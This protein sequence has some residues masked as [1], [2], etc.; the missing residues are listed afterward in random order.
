MSR[1]KSLFRRLIIRTLKIDIVTL[2]TTLTIIS[3]A[4]VIVYSYFVNYKAIL[5]YSKGTMER[6]SI[7]IIDRINNI[8]ERAIE[9][10]ENTSGLFI[11]T[12][13]I[14]VKNHELFPFMLNVLKFNQNLTAFFIGFSNGDML[15]AGNIRLSNQKNYLSEP[16]KP[17][18]NETAYRMWYV[19]IS[20]PVYHELW[21]YKDVNFNTIDKETIP[22]IIFPVKQRPWYIGAE[23][24]KQIFWTQVF[25]YFGMND[26]GVAVA[27][28]IYDQQGNLL[29]VIG[30]DISFHTMSNFIKKQKIGRSGR[31]YIISNTGTLIAP[32]A[33]E[34]AH[35][36]IPLPV[37]NAAFQDFQKNHHQNFSFKYQQKRYL[38]YFSS[39][40]SLFGQKWMILTIVP[41]NDFYAN[42]IHTQFEIVL[43]TLAILLISILIIIHF[44]K[45]ISKPI[46]KIGKEIDKIT[47]LDF[48]SKER[49]R[50][51]II[52]IRMINYSVLALKNAIRSFSR[53]VPKEIVKQLLAQGKAITLNVEKKT[54]TIFFSDIQNFTTISENYNIDKLMTLL[55]EYFDGLSKIILEHQGT[56][57]KYIGDS[58]MAFW[59]APIAMPD[60]AILACTAALKC[61]AYLAQFNQK[62]KEEGKPELITRFGISGGKVV[63]GNIGTRERMNYTVIG[64]AV[65]TASR[66]QLTDKIY[67]VNI[68]ISEEVYSHTHGEFLVRPLDTVEVRGKH[69]KIKIYEL[70]ALLRHDPSIGATAEQKELCEAFTKAYEVFQAGNY[71]AAQQLF[72][73]IHQK[74]P[75]DY[76]TEF[77][78]NR[79]RILLP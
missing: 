3:F 33:A 31:A 59:G 44:S 50:S 9:V 19:D 15:L 1:V 21:E 39:T 12:Q 43:I 32:T 29:A 36:K 73:E 75:Q 11:G 60:H 58:I 37:I 10:L 20:P 30:V 26:Q 46:V 48:S 6:N 79:I 24:T 57:D 8:E 56:I 68:I 64:D 66:L 49:V 78:L 41:F 23:K 27:K 70:V 14:N 17:L 63:V 53:Y 67:H 52:E 47:N 7:A 76:P 71:L 69:E 13:D 34:L 16:Q 72:T 4:F 51:N 40:E 74:F 18:P 2:F 65:N 25:N 77:Y 38:T 42:L 35:S 54:L 62:C 5:D 61:H 22:N 45:R 55:N 28:P